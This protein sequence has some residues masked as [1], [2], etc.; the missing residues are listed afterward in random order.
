MSPK[1]AHLSNALV[2]WEK[3]TLTRRFMDACDQFITLV[4]HREYT[5]GN[6]A[7]ARVYAPL[8]ASV[9]TILAIIFIT[10]VFGLLVPIES[11]A[12]A[13]GRVVVVGQRKTIQHL[14]GG[15]IKSILI[16]DGDV[17]KKGQPLIEISD[18]TP[19]ANRSIVQADLWNERV[20]EARLSSLRENKEEVHYPA[21]IMAEAKTNVDLAK[22]IQVQSALFV[23]QR[24]AQLGKLNTLK[25]RIAG[26]KEEIGGLQA[27]IQG[28]EGQM[29]FLKEEIVMMQTLLKQGLATK[30]RLLALQREMEALRGSRGQNIAQIAQIEQNI[31]EMD[32]QIINQENDFATQIAGE[33]KETQSKI[34]DFKERLSSAVDIM[35]R[36]VIVAPTEGVVTG[37]KMHTI[38]GIIHAGE[39]IL[40][41][42]PQNAQLILEVRV[43]PGDI[44]VVKPDLNAR[45]LLSAYKARRMPVLMGKV[46][47]VSA[48]AFTEQQ[49]AQLV[50]YYTAKVEVPQSEIHASGMPINLTPG[51]PADVYIRTG[52]RTFIGYLMAPITDSME[53]AFRE[54]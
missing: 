33:L 10:L 11:A 28:A 35:D 29:R 30:P 7:I 1:L 31:A 42:V 44:D 9:I 52:S 8:R 40:D 21:D 2:K 41:V 13:H 54:E 3:A 25:Q 14:E 46:T 51:M 34:N 37:L 26:Y 48:D 16:K 20:A 49:G 24:E 15:V 45:V 50:S 22:T 23:T 39:P 47:Q 38:G 53:Q 27:Q 43:Q 6:P 19:R 5:G 12:I 17:V 4:T 18:V 36:T 32:L